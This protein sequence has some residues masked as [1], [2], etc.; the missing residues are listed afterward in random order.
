MEF[1]KSSRSVPEA[2]AAVGSAGLKSR[3]DEILKKVGKG[4]SDLSTEASDAILEAAVSERASDV[5]VETHGAQLR[6]RLRVDG[7]LQECLTAPVHPDI[8]LAKRFR[9]LAGFDPNP[10]VPFRAEDGRFAKT[11]AGRPVQIRVSAFPTVNGEKIV[12]RVLDQANV[13]LALDQLGLTAENHALLDRMLRASYGIF[14]VTGAT[15][16]GKTTTLYSML[17]RINVKNANVMTLEDPVES[18]LDGINQGQINP[19]SGFTFEEGLR[20]ALRQDPDVIMIGE[21]RD[22]QTAEIAMRASLTGHLVL[23]TLHTIN[24]PTV[25]DRLFEMGVQP[26]LISSSMLGSMAQRLVRKLCVKCAQPS[27]APS[28]AS[29]QEL[30]K[31]LDNEEAKGVRELLLKPGA[32]FKRPVGCADCRGGYSGRVGIF[33]LMIM[34]EYLRTHILAKTQSDIL[35]RTAIQTGMRTLLMDGSLKA[36]SGVTTLDEVLRVTATLS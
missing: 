18:R 7:V 33:E 17:R 1:F 35:R 14:F 34:N 19:R 6:V 9:V 16:S 30:V 27:G 2:P 32:S 12:L 21:I 36:W 11:I 3:Y 31:T 24:A 22:Y 8:P 25:V 29:V 10:P 23:T 4:Q 26:F 15:G 5:H 28:E 20:A 13:L